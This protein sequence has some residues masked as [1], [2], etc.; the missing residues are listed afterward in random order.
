[1]G[2]RRPGPS[3]PPSPEQERAY[4]SRCCVYTHICAAW[5]GRG[6]GCSYFNL[7]APVFGCS[8]RPPIGSLEPRARLL[9][10]CKDKTLTPKYL[11]L[12]HP[13]IRATL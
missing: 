13:S 9:S 4:S 1:M 5:G 10:L 7:T 8:L 3:P 12:L 2:R 11:L 6:G